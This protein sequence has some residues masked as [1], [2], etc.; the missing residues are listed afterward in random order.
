M[1]CTAKH[2][3]LEVVF[4]ARKCGIYFNFMLVLAKNLNA[5]YHVAG[6]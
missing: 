3:L 5:T 2:G 1:A 4:F 6:L